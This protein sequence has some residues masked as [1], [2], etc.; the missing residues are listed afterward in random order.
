MRDFSLTELIRSV[1]I[2][3][4]SG[5]L[6]VRIRKLTHDSRLA[7][8]GSL[9]FALPGATTDGNLFIHKA[10][11][12]GARAILSEKPKPADVNVSWIEVKNATEAMGQ[13]A[14]TFFKFPSSTIT[15]LGVTGTNGKTTT[16]FM[17]TSI[18]N[19]TGQKTGLMSTIGYG[20]GNKFNSQVEHMTTV[21]GRILMKRLQSMKKQ[22]MDWLVLETTSHALAQNRVFGIPYSVAV[23]TNL[24]HEHLDYHLTFERYRTAKVK[25]FKLTNKNNR[26]LKL[27]IINSEDPSSQYFIKAITNPVTYGV[28][29]GDFVPENLR[30]S[31]S[32]F[33]Y[34]L[35]Y[36]N[37]KYSIKCHIPGRFNVYNSLAA[38]V[39]AIKLGLS[40]E[41]IF[42][43]LD[44]LKSVE[45]RMNLIDEGQAFEVIVDYAHSPDSFQKLF[46]EL[47]PIVK[48]RVIVL[49]GSAGERDVAK[50]AVQGELAGKF[51]DIVI[52][53][54]EDDRQEDG[55]QILNNIAEGVLGAGKKLDFNL[56]KILDRRQAIQK[57]F[58]LAQADDLVLLLGKGHEKSIIRRGGSISWNEIEVAKQEL[59]NLISNEK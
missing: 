50:R 14:N 57:A 11:Q 15:L 34:D 38:I 43:G 30:E 13:I 24:T 25:L 32:G 16:A 28:T 44:N 55:Q 46:E 59:R 10:I 9:F 5:S 52:L 47:Q 27:G 53:S 3:S 37:T 12:K 40:P 56:F 48:K 36:Q 29:Q 58:S 21:G 45:G 54:E 41:Q 4:L 6:D 22:G 18:L 39:V 23:F 19:Q 31:P 2:R 33:S 20:V 49:F 35:N 8:P 1:F 42:V 26:G 17:I 7:E 51:A